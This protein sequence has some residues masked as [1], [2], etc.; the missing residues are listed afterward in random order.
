MAHITEARELLSASE[1]QVLKSAIVEICTKQLFTGGINYHTVQSGESIESFT[2]LKQW[3]DDQSIKGSMP[4]LEN[5]NTSSIYGAE[6]NEL[7]RYWHDLTHL[8]LDCDFTVLS[9]LRVADEHKKQLRSLDVPER[10]IKLVYYDIAGQVQYYAKHKAFVCDGL[11]FVAMCDKHNIGYAVANFEDTE[12]TESTAKHLYF[13]L[14]RLGLHPVMKSMTGIQCGEWSMLPLKNGNIL[15]GSQDR[16][17]T[18]RNV[19]HLIN[20]IN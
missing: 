2:A 20:S 6:L 4:V 11:A 8:A 7:V 13:E 3:R 17:I 10:I 15:L 16:F 9:E 19:S 14:A 5:G 18:K 12:P 1:K